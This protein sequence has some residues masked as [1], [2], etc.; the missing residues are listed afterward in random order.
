MNISFFFF[1]ETAN[2]SFP[3]L[4]SQKENLRGSYEECDHKSVIESDHYLSKKDF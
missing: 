3:N 1:F 4:R 2:I